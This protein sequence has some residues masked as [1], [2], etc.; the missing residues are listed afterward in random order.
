MRFVLTL[1]VLGVWASFIS[2]LFTFSQ[3]TT[4]IFTSMCP[5]CSC[6]VCQATTRLPK[7]DSINYTNASTASFSCLA[8]KQG[9]LDQSWISMTLLEARRTLT[10]ATNLPNWFG[11]FTHKL[12]VG[13]DIQLGQAIVHS[14]MSVAACA[15]RPTK[16]LQTDNETIAGVGR[17]SSPAFIES[18]TVCNA[19]HPQKVVA[20]APP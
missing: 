12:W 11:W 10:C 4:R 3:P 9:N 5:I 20:E 6:V 15:G 16:P 8:T 1:Q 13:V 17:R 14:P 18:T 19:I 7:S 2:L